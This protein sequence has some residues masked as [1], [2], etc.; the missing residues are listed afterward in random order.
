MWSTS[1]GL[2]RGNCQVGLSALVGGGLAREGAVHPG[3][4]GISWHGHTNLHA[5]TGTT[6]VRSKYMKRI[7][8]GKEVPHTGVCGEEVVCHGLAGQVFGAA[9][10]EQ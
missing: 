9:I 2:G 5:V 1:D 8:G 3:V 6:G 4:S 7:R 10:I